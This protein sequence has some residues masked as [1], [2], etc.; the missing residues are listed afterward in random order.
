MFSVIFH[1][2]MVGIRPVRERNM[3]A[4]HPRAEECAYRPASREAPGGSSID[5][6]V[7]GPAD[8]HAKA[9]PA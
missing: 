6:R 3:R 4:P 2:R 1:F 9:P 5:H 7:D 8:G